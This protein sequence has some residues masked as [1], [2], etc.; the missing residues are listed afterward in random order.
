MNVAAAEDMNQLKM[1]PCPNPLHP[2][3]KKALQ[4]QNG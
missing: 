2:A 3:T 4:N 1:W